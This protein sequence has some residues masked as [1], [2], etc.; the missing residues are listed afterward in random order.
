MAY[1][2]VARHEEAIAE[3]EKALSLSAGEPG[4]LGALG[5][6]YAISGKRAEA[7][8]ALAELKELSKRRYVA[9]YDLAL[10][11]T[12]LGEKAQA[13]EWLE[14][15]YEDH[16]QRLTWI[17]VWPQFDSLRREPRFQN[18]LRRMGLGS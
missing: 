3:C 16:S 12:G 4:A 2:P 7:L 17:K 11:Y 8:K 9:P 10:I 13:L 14:K 18:L 15:A 6:A 5:H 1:E